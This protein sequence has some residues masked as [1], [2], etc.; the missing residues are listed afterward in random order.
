MID[1]SNSNRN[2]IERKCGIGAW[3]IEIEIGR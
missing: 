3:S 2:E 1:D